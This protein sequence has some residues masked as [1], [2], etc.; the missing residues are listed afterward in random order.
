MNIVRTR[1]SFVV[2]RAW[3]A[4]GLLA[5]C[6]KEGRVLDRDAGPPCDPSG[7]SELMCSDGRDDD[8]DGFADCL[9]SECEAMTCGS[10]A[11]LTCTAGAC[12]M[13]CDPDDEGCLPT[14]PPVV[15]VR[16]NVFDQTLR[17]DFEPVAGAKDYR[18]YV[19]PSPEDILVGENG[20]VA[21]RN[22][23]Y[24][25]AGQRPVQSRANDPSAFPDASYNFD[26][27]RGRGFG[28]TNADAPLGHVF[29]TPRADR[30]PV[31]RMAEPNG[32]GGFWNSDWVVT[33]MAEGNSA[34]YVAGVAERDRLVALGYRDDGIVFYAPVDGTLPV[35]RAKY[36]PSFWGDNTSYFFTAG[37]EHDA[38]VTHM[39]TVDFGERFRIHAA[40]TEDSVPLHR[41]FYL[42]GNAHDVLAAGAAKLERVLYQGNVPVPSLT[43]S[44]LTEETTFVIEA[45]DSGCPFPNAYIG[46][47]AAPSDPGNHGTVTLDEA[48]LSSG[49]VFVNG[50]F[51]STNRPKPIARA[52]VTVSPGARPTM[53]WQQTFD[54]GTEL[55]PFTVQTENNGVFVMRNSTMGADFSGCSTNLSFGSLLGQ[56]VVGFADYG[57]SCNMSI[58]PRGYSTTISSG[59]YVHMR[60]TTDI[61]S[62]GRRYPQMMLTTTPALDPASNNTLYNI[63]LHS[64]LGPLP[65]DINGP[66]GIRG[67][68]DDGELG[69]EVSIIVQPFGGNHELQIQICDRRGWGVG[70]QCSQANVYG[71]HAGNYTETWEEP[72]TPVPVLGERAGHDRPVRFDVY[73]STQRVYVYVDGDP[74]GCA[75]LPNGMMPQGAVTPAFRAV[76]YHSDIDETVTPDNSSHRYLHDYSLVHTRRTLDDLGVEQG[77]Q[78]PY[79]D[80]SVLPCGTRWYGGG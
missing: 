56:L 26:A 60:M 43:W 22:A 58:F 16:P 12:L 68:A 47:V 5:A 41:V 48:R 66:D 29:L 44:S 18:I 31:Y 49:E 37:P 1:T 33:P 11:G 70:N 25:C 65:F 38:R 28:R 51:P 59:S 78:V 8:C 34:D 7:A 57:S 2:T 15:N 24:R 23:I 35:Y 39:D 6:S 10:T 13:P 3:L 77:V 19:N 45:L 69:E 79:W 46:A 21:V 62:T 63:L 30:V 27:E 4:L 40:P 61:P 71:H 36:A 55:E 53:T 74:A 14:L 52:Y 76:L 50:Q 32:A 67:T 54:P 64:R 42:A 80:E 9:D 73:A 17:V 20:E 72:W 75:V